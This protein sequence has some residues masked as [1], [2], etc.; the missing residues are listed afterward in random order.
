MDFN[1]VYQVVFVKCEESSLSFFCD[2]PG[3]TIAEKI[4]IQGKECP[5]LQSGN[6]DL[7]ML[8]EKETIE[9]DT[10]VLKTDDCVRDYYL[11]N[12]KNIPGLTKPRYVAH[13]MELCFLDPSGN[14]FILTEERDY[15]EA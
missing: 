15:S 11:F 4:E 13:G 2:I 12:Q 1:Q 9:A 3:F 7:I 6:G 5:I 8:V 14:R 10:I